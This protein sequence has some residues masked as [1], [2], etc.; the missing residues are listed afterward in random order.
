MTIKIWHSYSCNNSSSFRLVARFADAATARAVADELAAFFPH[1]AAE[2]DRLMED[3]DVPDDNGEVARELAERYGFVWKDILVWGDTG[4]TGDE[5]AVVA[6]HEVLVVYHTY[7]G[8]F[9]DL[10]DYLARR[11]ATV[12]QEDTSAPFVS[13]LFAERPGDA[14]LD[15]GITQLCAQLDGEF[16]DDAIQTPWKTRWECYGRGACFRDGKTVGLYFPISPTDLVT[17]R[18]W[19]AEHGVERTVIR[20]CEY[21][22]RERF[23]AIAA[24][25]CRS[26][27][28]GLEYLDPG[29]HDIETPQLLCRP[30]GGLYELAAFAP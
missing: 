18:A 26:C 7:C 30:C 23:R 8:G 12:E 2:M 3:G 10:S 22:D 29:L 28:G 1:H 19:L 16:R 5:P 20:L 21:A 25:R 13:L 27:N 6:E 4:M 17:C 15:G 9:G 11:G 14:E 24:A